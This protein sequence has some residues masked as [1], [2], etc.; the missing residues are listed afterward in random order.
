MILVHSLI[1]ELKEQSH[2]FILFSKY[3]KGNS[4]VSSCQ[5]QYINLHHNSSQLFFTYLY[6]LSWHS[7]RSSVKCPVCHTFDSTMGLL[8]GHA[9][10]LNFRNLF[11]SNAWPSTTVVSIARKKSWQGCFHHSFEVLVGIASCQS[12]CWTPYHTPQAAI[13]L[14]PF[15]SLEE[16]GADTSPQSFWYLL[17]NSEGT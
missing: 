15:S 6:M 2:F 16:A 4:I 9:V 8:P 10:F 12:L 17:P 11:S 3:R 1:V 5:M 13:L 14:I 7:R